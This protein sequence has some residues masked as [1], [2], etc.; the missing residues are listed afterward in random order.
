[1]SSS[2]EEFLYQFARKNSFPENEHTIVKDNGNGSVCVSF[3]PA[4]C[5]LFQAEKYAL[6]RVLKGSE[7][8]VSFMEF[9]LVNWSSFVKG[10]IDSFPRFRVGYATEGSR[11]VFGVSSL[12]EAFA[13]HAKGAD[14][15]PPLMDGEWRGI[16]IE[17]DT[18]QM[19]F[20]HHDHLCHFDRSIELE[21]GP[22]FPS[23]VFLTSKSVLRK[24]SAV[25]FE[26][27]FRFTNTLYNVEQHV[28]E[29]REDIASYKELVKKYGMN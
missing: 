10:G 1:V 8:R 6:P 14:I 2:L 9:R 28:E 19:F 7:P 29:R 3:F 25:V 4:E 18:K 24:S 26:M 27:E 17:W 5:S 16:G 23:V 15:V 11:D 13:T 22:L 12:G 20:T 21:K